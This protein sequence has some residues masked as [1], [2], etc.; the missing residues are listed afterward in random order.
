[1][2]K[3]V[4]EMYINE[5]DTKDVVVIKEEE[6]TKDSMADLAELEVEVEAKYIALNASKWPYASWLSIKRQ[7]WPVTF[8]YMW[9]RRSLPRGLP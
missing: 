2:C 5:M 3:E 4:K 7:N 8:S 9:F 6:V 1:M